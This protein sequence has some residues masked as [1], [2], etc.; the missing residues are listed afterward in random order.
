MDILIGGIGLFI[1]FY[2][3]RLGIYMLHYLNAHKKADK[4]IKS[5]SI[6]SGIMVKHGM[7][8]DPKTGIVRGTTS[9]STYAIK[10]FMK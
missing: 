5:C 1:G 7:V 3:I 10:H 8:I 2:L 4:Y 9:P 6:D